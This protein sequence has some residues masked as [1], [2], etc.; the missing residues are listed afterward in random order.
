MTDFIAIP[1][2]YGPPFHKLLG[3]RMGIGPN[4]EGVAW[5]GPEPGPAAAAEGAERIAVAV[6]GCEPHEIR[7]PAATSP[8]LAA[9]DGG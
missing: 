9:P 4:K 8:P 1:E 3:V 7:A 6:A 2:G 5:V